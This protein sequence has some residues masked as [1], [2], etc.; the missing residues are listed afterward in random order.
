MAKVEQVYF[1]DIDEGDVISGW[2][3]VENVS[4]THFVRYAGASGDFNPMHHDDTIAQKVGY[5]SVFG[6]GMFSAG[7]LSGYVTDWVGIGNTRKFGTE[8]RKQLFPGATLSITGTV[9]KKYKEGDENRID[10]EFEM[11]DQNDSLILKAKMTAALPSR[12]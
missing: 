3:P 1:E 12:G 7:V 6:H 5:P 8:F 4:R 11:K 9:V 10:A 2:P